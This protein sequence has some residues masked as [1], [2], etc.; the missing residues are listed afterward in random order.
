M[1]IDG[2]LLRQ[3]EFFKSEKVHIPENFILRCTIQIAKGL[4]YAHDRDICHSDIK[5]D[6][7]FLTESGQLK[8]G[9]LGIS[10]VVVTHAGQITKK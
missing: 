9:D 10:K 4:K 1:F 6:N 8:L 5:P 3:F 7:I 2:D